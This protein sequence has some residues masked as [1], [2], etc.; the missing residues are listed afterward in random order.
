MD[1]QSFYQWMIGGDGRWSI[2]DIKE[3][4]GKSDLVWNHQK[5]RRSID[6][7]TDRISETPFFREGSSTR[8]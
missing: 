7:S 6:W 2:Q 1:S 4:L 3:K 8:F 5:Q